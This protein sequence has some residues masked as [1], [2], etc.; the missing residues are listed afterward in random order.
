V[1][2]T[3]RSRIPRT[4]VDASD[5]GAA[6]RA[7]RERRDAIAAGERNEADRAIRERLR[8][9]VRELRPAALA[10]YWPMRGEPDVIE[11]LSAWHEEG[12]VVALPRVV[13]PDA[14]L[15][16]ECWRPGLRLVSGVFGTSEPP[17]GER[18]V[19]PDLLVM[20]CLGFDAHCY[21]LGYG[22]GFYDRTLAALPGARAIGVAYDECEMRAFAAQPHDRPLDAVV[23]QARLLRRNS[24]EA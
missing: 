16:F 6:R 20:P 19:S 4:P 22:G 13:A 23:T 15:R 7:L 14:P 17:A 5:R 24:R 21:R 12:I 3:S 8:Q 2:E 1:Y 10:A 11:L 18:P 9:A